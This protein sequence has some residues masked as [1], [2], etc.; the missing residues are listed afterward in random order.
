M[1]KV[2]GGISS[3]RGLSLV[4]KIDYVKRKENAKKLAGL[5]DRT[6]LAFLI[7]KHDSD[8]RPLTAQ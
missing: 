5:M 8:S 1:S 4:T 2:P 7:P 6:F 3:R